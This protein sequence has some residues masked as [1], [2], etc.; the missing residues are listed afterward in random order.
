MN[1]SLA[2]GAPLCRKGRRDHGLG[3]AAEIEQRQRFGDDIASQGRIYF[4][5]DDVETAHPEVTHDFVYAG[6][7]LHLRQMPGI[8]V[9][10][11]HAG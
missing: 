11:D 4:L 7:G 6:N 1:D 8:G 2:N 3:P 9:D 10:R 5:D